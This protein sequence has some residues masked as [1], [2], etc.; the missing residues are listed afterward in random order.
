MRVPR[1]FLQEVGGHGK[2]FAIARIAEMFLMR[3][4]ASILTKT[5]H[6]SLPIELAED[7]GKHAM[8]AAIRDEEA[9]RIVE[10]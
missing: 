3:R 4:G 8:A 9:R 10:V 5:K 2:S 7:R 1:L 6:G